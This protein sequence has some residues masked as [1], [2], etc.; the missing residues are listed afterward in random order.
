[1]QTGVEPVLALCTCAVG[2]TL[3]HHGATTGALQGIVADFG[4]GIHGLVHIA[5]LQDLARTLCVVGLH[6][7]QAVGMHQ[8]LGKVTPF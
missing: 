3:G 1:L 5:V 4:G 2:K 7:R 6:A 8:A